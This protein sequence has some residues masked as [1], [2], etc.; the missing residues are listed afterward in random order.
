MP[1]F[2]KTPAQE[3]AWTR[4]K[5]AVKKQYPDIGEDSDRYYALVTSIYQNM[6]SLRKASMCP[7]PLLRAAVKCL[8]AVPLAKRAG[9]VPR[10][11]GVVQ[12]CVDQLAKTRLGRM[13]PVQHS[14]ACVLVLHKAHVE[15]YWRAS[16]SGQHHWV[17]AHEQQTGQRPWSAKVHEHGEGDKKTYRVVM[18]GVVPHPGDHPHPDSAYMMGRIHTG[19][20]MPDVPHDYGSGHLVEHY[21]RMSDAD[22]ETARQQAETGART[23]PV[24]VTRTEHAWRHALAMHE[25]QERVKGAGGSGKTPSPTR[26]VTLAGRSA[27]LPTRPHTLGGAT[28]EAHNETMR[29]FVQRVPKNQMHQH[30]DQMSTGALQTLRTNLAQYGAF[31]AQGTHW[32][33]T[34]AHLYQI[35]QAL[36]ARRKQ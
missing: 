8:G 20:P 15:G 26:K 11:A 4:A 19:S 7:A 14:T 10:V 17:S 32:E 25:Q 6:K 24:G 31:H 1:A 18:D 36:R 2:I 33:H 5:A 13:T 29:D 12:R 22:L 16:P 35:E 3:A 30:T 28:L 23:H 27:S 34:N 9:L 21:G